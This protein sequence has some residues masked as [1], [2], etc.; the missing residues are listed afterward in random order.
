VINPRT[1]ERA[2]AGFPE[3]RSC[4]FR[5]C[6]E[7]RRGSAPH[8]AIWSL[9]AVADPRGN[10]YQGRCSPEPTTV[11]PFDFT[12]LLWASAIGYLLFAEIPDPLTLLGGSIILASVTYVAYRERRAA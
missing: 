3:S 11:L 6:D 12:K 8:R 5:L 4:G 9:V 1:N 10:G 2:D 7:R